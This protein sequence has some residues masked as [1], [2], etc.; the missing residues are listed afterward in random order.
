M[1]SISKAGVWIDCK[2]LLPETYKLV[3]Y[4]NNA[5]KIRIGDRLIQLNNR[6]KIDYIHQKITA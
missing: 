6:L 1:S 2:Q 3:N 4:L 5:D